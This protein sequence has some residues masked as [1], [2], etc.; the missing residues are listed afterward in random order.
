MMLSDSVLLSASS[1]R[2]NHNR[3]TM[4]KF[5]RKVNNIF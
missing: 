3:T 2:Q 4:A 5:G 1:C